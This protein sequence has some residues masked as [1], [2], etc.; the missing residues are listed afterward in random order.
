MIGKA[1]FECLISL[2]ILE[3]KDLRTDD[4]TLRYLYWKKG[5]SLRIIRH[6]LKYKNHF[7]LLQRQ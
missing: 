6:V 7:A 4:N 1:V 2:N 3:D 5:V